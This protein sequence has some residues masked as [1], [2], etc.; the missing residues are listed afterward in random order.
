MRLFGPRRCS[1]SK[2]HPSY[3][4][5]EFQGNPPKQK[6]IPPRKWTKVAPFQKEISS[7]NHCFSGDVL[8]LLGFREGG[9]VIFVIR[10]VCV[11]VKWISWSVYQS[12]SFKRRGCT[13]MKSFIS[14]PWSLPMYRFCL[15]N[16][17][18]TTTFKVLAF[19]P[20][21][22]VVEK[23]DRSVPKPMDLWDLGARLR[24]GAWR[25]IS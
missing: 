22:R 2:I 19:F 18:T 23:C 11:C 16:F 25:I 17:Q 20:G 21:G 15:V 13:I 9:K 7:S 5:S 14:Q 8:E 3:I 4:N 6:K 1:C 12:L 24:L 10:G